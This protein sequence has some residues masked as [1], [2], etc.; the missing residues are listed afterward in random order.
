[1]ISLDFIRGGWKFTLSKISDRHE[2]AVWDRIAREY[3]DGSVLDMAAGE[4][5]F[6][7]HFATETVGKS[8]PK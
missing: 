4:R 3:G 5:I 8:H 1:M 2:Q 6:A 7:K